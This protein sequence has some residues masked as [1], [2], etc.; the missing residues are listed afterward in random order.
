MRQARDGL[1]SRI[2]GYTEKVPE[3]SAF[4]M[5]AL[6][7][8]VYPAKEILCAAPDE[9]VLIDIKAFWDPAEVRAAGIN[10]WRL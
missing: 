8:A 1:L 9:A 4:A 3:A 6:L 5:C 10:Y 7:S 2:C